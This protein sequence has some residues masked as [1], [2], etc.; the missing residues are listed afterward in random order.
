[1]TDLFR[2]HLAD[3]TDKNLRDRISVRLAWLLEARRCTHF[4]IMGSAQQQGLVLPDDGY[5]PGPATTQLAS[6]ALRNRKVMFSDLYM[7]GPDKKIYLDIA[8]PILT[9]PP[10]HW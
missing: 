4:S 8:I 1:M 10:A 3:P 7:P 9:T 6:A 5:F 2:R